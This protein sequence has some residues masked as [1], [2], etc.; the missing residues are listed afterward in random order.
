[1]IAFTSVPERIACAQ[2]PFMLYDPH[3][4]AYISLHVC[5]SLRGLAVLRS[6]ETCLERCPI[7]CTSM[8]GVSCCVGPEVTAAAAAADQLD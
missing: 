6:H 3:S 5:V 2:P 1:M 4:L 8:Y 7:V